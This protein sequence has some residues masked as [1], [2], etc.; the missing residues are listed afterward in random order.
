MEKRQYELCI[1]ILR[2]FHKT[3]ILD[4]FILVGSW[5][6][7]FYKDYFVDVPY[8]N[9][10]TIKTRD[11]D[12]LINAPARIKH[13]VDIPAL[14]KDLGFIVAFSGSEGYIKLDHPDIVLEFLVPEKGRNTDKPY[15][16]PKLGVNAVALRFLNF[17]SNNTIKVKCEDFY[18]TLPHPVNF[19]LH[20]LIIFQRRIKEEKAL[21]DRYTAIE[22]LK[23]L[24]KKGD[25]SIIKKVFDSVHPKWQK[26]IVK[27]LE[28]V[29]E[30]EILN[31]LK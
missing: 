18:L 26:R 19:A 30:Q 23:A 3:G 11:I 25:T 16:L 29:K 24:I 2:R 28:M 21:K 15:P 12:F 10:I 22:V 6:V 5:C 27:G 17:L 14:L 7:Y 31:V 20:K 4:D 13:E 1:E 9:Q 8:I